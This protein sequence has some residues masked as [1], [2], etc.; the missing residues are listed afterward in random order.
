[1]RNLGNRCKVKNIAKRKQNFKKKV[2]QAKPDL[3]SILNH[4]GRQDQSYNYNITLSI[5]RLSL[6]DCQQKQI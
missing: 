5:T 4:I 2:I 3:L 1:M 6:F